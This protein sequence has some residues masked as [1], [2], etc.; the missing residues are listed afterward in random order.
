MYFIY[1]KKD[2]LVAKIRKTLQLFCWLQERYF[3]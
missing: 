2:Y 1:C 3:I